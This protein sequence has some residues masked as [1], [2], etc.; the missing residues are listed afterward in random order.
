MK[1]IL[2]LVAICLFLFSKGQT[3]QYL[4]SPTTQIYIRGQLRIDTVVY[5]PLRDTTFTP[6]QVGALVVKSTVPYLWT[7]TKWTAIATGNPIWGTLQGTLSDQT[8][9]QN[10]LNAKQNSLSAGYGIKIATNTLLFDSATVRKV[11]TIYRQNDSTLVFTIN[12]ASRSVLLRGTAAGGINSLILNVPSTLFSDPITFNNTG[13]AWSGTMALENQDANTF[14][15]GPSIGSPGQPSFRAIV[16]ADLPTGIPNANLQNSSIGVSIG[17]SGTNITATPGTVSLGSTLTISIPTASSAARGA[18]T[19]NDWIFFNGKMDSIHISGD[20]VYNCVNGVCTLVSVLPILTVSFDQGLFDSSN[21][22]QLGEPLNQSGNPAQFYQHREIPLAG[23]SLT[24]WDTANNVLGGKMVFNDT[25]YTSLIGNAK[26]Q[27]R[28]FA[29]RGNDAYMWNT[30]Y[31]RNYGTLYANGKPNGAPMKALG[32]SWGYSENTSGGLPAPDNVFGGGYNCINATARA[33]TGDAALSLRVET[34]FNVLGTHGAFEMHWPELTRFTG[35]QQRI[36]SWYIDKR[37]GNTLWESNLNLHEYKKIFQHVGEDWL[38]FNSNGDDFPSMTFYGTHANSLDGDIVFT[39]S[40]GTTALIRSLDTDLEFA[41]G[42]GKHPLHLNKDGTIWMNNTLT[43]T[44]PNANTLIGNY[45]DGSFPA[46]S[47][48]AQLAVVSQHRGFLPPAMTDA[49]MSAISSPAN[50]LMIYNTTQNQP[51]VYENTNWQPLASGGSTAPTGSNGSIQIKSATTGGFGSAKNLIADSATG[52]VT[53]ASLSV[54]DSAAN[55]FISINSFSDFVD[56]HAGIK[57]TKTSSG[58]SYPD[59]L[60]VGNNSFDLG[61]AS[62]D[63]S[64]AAI[65]FDTRSDFDVPPIRIFVHDAGASSDITAMG[66]H[67]NGGIEIGGAITTADQTTSWFRV[68]P[69]STTR[70]QIMLDSAVAVS[71]PVANTLNNIG[72]Y[73]TWTNNR[74]HYDTLATLD[75]VRSN[76]NNGIQNYQ[77]SIFTPATGGTVN[78]N[79]KQFNIIN[80]AGALATLTVNLPSSPANNDVVYI[81]YTQS[82]TAVT[83][84]NGTVVDGITAPAAGGLVVLVYDSGTSSWY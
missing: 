62:S 57:A 56:Q 83:Y 81:K 66:I 10:A 26:V 80:P 75:L 51:Y 24:W 7:G 23:K 79:N 20:S 53:M 8:D 36:N 77:H 63:N 25:Q 34:N 54:A 82:I 21:T 29:D 32:W 18:L 42:S 5:F 64:G 84:G 41:V 48:S 14:F 33:D 52:H 35:V 45:D 39:D 38:K 61:V 27:M 71:S 31:P 72:Q 2:T 60:I 59:F 76:P 58:A 67:E 19:S 13:G 15:G 43:A 44:A 37:T 12:G 50:G 16:T 1:L 4:G 28:Q 55:T 70:A 49:Q 11:D 46:N 73:L 17:S 68:R 3:I 74:T 22:I 69:G 65:S 9:L 6:S 47:N 40:S 78:L 30:W